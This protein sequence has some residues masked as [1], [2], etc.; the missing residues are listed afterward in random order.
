MLTFIESGVFIY[1]LAA[2]AGVGIITKLVSA[3]RYSRL[4][5]QAE[6]VALTG[7][8]YIRLWKNKFENAYR[9]NK[10][11][12]DPE[13]F[14][15]R[16]INQ[17]R[18]LGLQLSKW[19]RL[20]RVLCSVC[21][22]LSAVAVTVEVRGGVETALVLDHFLTSLSI[23]SLMVFIEVFCETGE[24]RQRIG[25]NLTE[26]FVNTL[27][28]RLQNGSETVTAEAEGLRRDL[29]DQETDFKSNKKE[30]IHGLSREES[31]LDKERE[32]ALRESL[33]RIAA[34]RELEDDGR[35]EKR[36][37]AKREEDA[38]LIEEILREYLR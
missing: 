25:L 29:R 13:L 6:D 31:R 20:N 26:Y 23:C 10:G 24:K 9:I 37:R 8:T 21:L 15:E 35:R 2:I 33:E 14:V 3:V 22:V 5:H 38:R 28:H 4:E 27:S 36:S 7:D 17:C 16:C 34:S 19:D 18:M 1:V 12:N 32:L 11:M 30:G